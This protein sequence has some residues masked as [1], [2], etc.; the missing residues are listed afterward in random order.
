MSLNCLTCSQVQ[1]SNSE[2]DRKQ[3]GK[4]R[5]CTKISNAH[6]DRSWSGNLASPPSYEQFCMKNAS[7]LV[8]HKKVTQGHRRLHSTGAVA[9]EGGAEPRLV[10]SSGMRRD[11]S[12]E[13]LRQRDEKKG[14]TA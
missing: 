12:F 1:R 9:F 13:D 7:M 11:W 3:H 10:R 2:S 14:R 5:N 6:V 8:A 4:D